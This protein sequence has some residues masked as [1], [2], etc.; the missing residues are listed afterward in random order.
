MLELKTVIPN[1]FAVA[2][3]PV[4]EDLD[5]LAEQGYRT[6]ISNRPDNE[7]QN[8]PTAEDMRAAAERQGLNYVHIPVTLGSISRRDIEVFRDSLEKAPAPAVAHCGSGK[9]AYL[10][11]AAGEVL[12][13][14]R[15]IQELTDKAAGIGIDA[16]ELHQ[17]VQ[18]AA[19]Q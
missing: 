16:K 8:Q 17:I 19:E 15:D 3:Q 4:P 6:L 9:R 14:G 12:H 5:Q 11:W 1:E 13:Q 10:L 18:Q 7:K 2:A